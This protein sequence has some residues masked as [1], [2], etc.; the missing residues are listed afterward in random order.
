[1]PRKY[2]KALAIAA[3]F[4]VILVAG[5]VT[6]TLLAVWA[7]SAER[8]ATRQRISA[9]AAKQEAV[10]QAGQAEKNFAEAQRQRAQAVALLYR[11]LT[12]EAR[13]IREARGSGY[14]V[15]AWNRLEQASRL[16]TPEKDLTELRWEAGACLGDFVGLEPTDWQ[17]P[18]GTRI[19]ACDLHPGGELLAIVLI[20]QATSEV[21]LRNVVT[22]REVGRLR[23]EGE[24][25]TCVKFSVDGKRLF[26]GDFKGVVK[27]WQADPGGNWLGEKALTPAPEPSRSAGR[28]LAVSQ[29]G[30]LLAACSPS[31]RAITVWNLTDGSLA[32]AFHA[33]DGVPAGESTLTDVAFSPRGDLMAAGLAGGDLDGVLMAAGLADGDLDG[34]LIW[35]VPTRKMRRT[36]RPGFGPVFNIC[37]SADGKYLACACRDGIVLFDTADFQRHLFAKGGGPWGR[38]RMSAFSPD[39]RL[40]AV[41]APEA[42]LVRL[43]N[44]TTNQ[45]V[46]VPIGAI[47]WG[48][49]SSDSLA[50]ANAWFQPGADRAA[51]GISR[52]LLR[53][54][55]CPDTA[56]GFPVW[57]SAPMASSL[58]R[59]AKTMSCESGTPVR[60]RSFASCAGLLRRLRVWPSTQTAISLP[61]PNTTDRA[62]SS[63]GMPDPA[64]NYPPFLTTSARGSWAPPLAVTESI[65][66]SVENSA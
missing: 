51:S 1:M 55:P 16:Q 47:P 19:N 33:P 35:D 30:T 52:A 57:R 6:S 60:E 59:P 7:R 64:S 9:E 29:D 12:G 50:T 43:W 23:P 36:L 15:E 22:G 58:H 46:T 44:I 40:L 32:P 48:R 3:A 2:K 56:A 42:G 54:R 31:S 27:V 39:S 4:A 34:V 61:R 10:A 14:R 21:L 26:A 38:D 65:S 49:P 28:Q 17:A 8:E 41:P 66:S 18:A 5:L 53:N 63:S 37:F 20:G 62:R 45:E 24:P 13:A 25:F 11:S